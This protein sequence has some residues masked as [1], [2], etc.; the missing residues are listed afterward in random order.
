MD[1]TQRLSKETLSLIVDE[2]AFDD[3]LRISHVSKRLQVTAREN[4]SFWD[5][6]VIDSTA[7]ASLKKYTA[8]LFASE[9][10]DIT[11]TVRL[12]R[13]DPIVPASVLPQIEA[14]LHRISHLHIVVHRLYEEHLYK[15]LQGPA[16]RLRTLYLEMRLAT[17]TARHIPI[18]P[19]HIFDGYAPLLER[20]AVILRGI[21]APNL[22]SDAHALVSRF[23]PDHS[24]RC[25][26][27]MLCNIFDWLSISDLFRASQVSRRWRNIGRDRPTLW[28]TV[29]LRISSKAALH[30]FDYLVSISA[31]REIEIEVVLPHDDEDVTPAAL[32]TIEKNLWRTRRLHLIT[33]PCYSRHTFKALY[34][35]APALRALTLGFSQFS[36]SNQYVPCELFVG[37][38]PV[39]RSVT[40]RNVCMSQSVRVSAFLEVEWASYQETSP[41]IAE[42]YGPH[43]SPL[44]LLKAFPAAQSLQI[45]YCYRSLAIDEGEDAALIKEAYRL[46]VLD[47]GDTNL[48]YV[49]PGAFDVKDL[50]VRRHI[51]FSDEM[52]SLSGPLRCK[53]HMLSESRVRYM[54]LSLTST[55]TGR[56]LHFRHRLSTFQAARYYLYDHA[57]EH[58]GQWAEEIVELQVLQSL[59][60]DA[61]DCLPPCPNATNIILTL[62]V[63][64]GSLAGLLGD[65]PVS[66]LRA[67]R[68]TV[69]TSFDYCFVGVEELC[70]FVATC[71]DL[72]DNFKLELEVKGHVV[73][74]GDRSQL[75]ESFSRV[76]NTP[77]RG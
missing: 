62:D 8:R 20:D 33:E 51:P 59:W 50:Y 19:N 24:S 2:M 58:G 32:G 13:V 18:F 70:A 35:A 56:A 17:A 40:L 14:N 43:L 36:T 25:P 12:P 15:A 69:E 64:G 23:F 47:V 73:I 77:H 10:P 22:K 75:Y 7:P 42:Y 76:I 63:D 57:T 72:P 41:D 46:Q 28:R 9:K 38:A 1:F 61:I 52:T 39:L 4:R 68:L 60:K 16:P 6:I 74:T 29:Q 55:R 53:I 21:Q 11:V 44:H 37:C 71:I 67:R 66:F 34:H 26:D 48:L 65:Q 31:Q 45:P 27:E 3:V 5:D 54:F 49:L 30:L